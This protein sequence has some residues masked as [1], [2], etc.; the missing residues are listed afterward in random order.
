MIDR[1]FADRVVLSLADK[2]RRN[3]GESLFEIDFRDRIKNQVS[4]NCGK[5]SNSMKFFSSGTPDLLF[6]PE[7]AFTFE[8]HP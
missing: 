3:E 4:P 5:R 8:R 7:T 2:D 6:K 1:R